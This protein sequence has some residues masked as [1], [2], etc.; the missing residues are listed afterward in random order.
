VPGKK[1][2]SLSEPK[3]LVQEIG[4]T[5]VP[6]TVGMYVEVHSIWQPHTMACNTWDLQRSVIT[7]YDAYSSKPR[8]SSAL[9]IRVQC[10]R[11]GATITWLHRG[12]EARC[13]KHTAFRLKTSDPRNHLC[14]IGTSIAEH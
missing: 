6:Q 5:E 10:R 1:P 13:L 9:Q 8:T 2:R 14:A 3:K 12:G 11:G 4:H 7:A